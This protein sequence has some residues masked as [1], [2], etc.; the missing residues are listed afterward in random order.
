M[1]FEILHRTN[2]ESPF[3]L[4]GG[5][6]TARTPHTDVWAGVLRGAGCAAQN[7]RKGV[8]FNGGVFLLNQQPLHTTPLD[9]MFLNDFIDI[10]LPFIGIPNTLRVKR[11]LWGRGS[12]G[13][14]SLKD[15]R[16]CRRALQF[17][18]ISHVLLRTNKGL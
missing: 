13:R 18:V 14:G 6:A 17:Q 10:R 5:E 11:R 3:P 12:S 15:S 9:Q 1:S 4:A 16:V 7:D 8:L 2:K